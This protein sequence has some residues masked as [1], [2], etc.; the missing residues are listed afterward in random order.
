[1]LACK[2]FSLPSAGGVGWPCGMAD[3]HSDE[4]W[5]SI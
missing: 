5:V 1:M 4:D 3:V 2:F